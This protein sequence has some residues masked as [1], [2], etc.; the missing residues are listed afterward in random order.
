MRRVYDGYVEVSVL[1]LKLGFFYVKVLL[2]F[3]EGV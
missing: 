1:Y 3:N 2:R